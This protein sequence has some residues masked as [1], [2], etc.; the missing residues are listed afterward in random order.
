MILIV[1]VLIS[2]V[3]VGG[4]MR[5]EGVI[6]EFV[7]MRVLCFVVRCVV[8]CCVMFWLCYSVGI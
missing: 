1:C 8:V 6:V 3:C 5:K 7:N 4:L 2:M